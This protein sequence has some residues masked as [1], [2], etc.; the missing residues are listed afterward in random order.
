MNKLTKAVVLEHNAEHQLFDVDVDDN[1]NAI[2][3]SQDDRPIVKVDKT[4][5]LP[6]IIDSTNG[7]IAQDLQQM[8]EDDNHKNVETVI[9][10]GGMLHKTTPETP[11]ILSDATVRLAVTTH[12]HDTEVMNVTDDKNMDEKKN[13]ATYDKNDVES[14]VVTTSESSLTRQNEFINHGLA[15]W[16][17]NRQRWLQRP[18][19]T[20][21]TTNNNY[22]NSLLL[23]NKHAKPINVDEIIDALFTSHKKL[24]LLNNNNNGGLSDTTTIPFPHAVPLPQLVDILQDLW[25][26][27]ST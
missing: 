23:S 25:E 17:I 20:V 1:N 2:R 8:D 5:T 26:A 9:L 21:A 13:H 11:S 16:E 27:E 15:T 3:S 14:E 12:N 18:I 7:A 24:L 22:N 19:D 4:T 6:P 10:T